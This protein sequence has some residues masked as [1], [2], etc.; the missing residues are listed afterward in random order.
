LP[1]FQYRKR[2]SPRGPS[3][4]ALKIAR[5]EAE[6]RKIEQSPTFGQQFPNVR[7]LEIFWAMKTETGALIADSRTTLKRDKPLLMDLKCEGG[8]G[9]GIFQLTDAI[10][11]GLQN[12]RES[13]AG[14]GTCAAA[15]YKDPLKR[16]GA[17]LD[18][19]V[20]AVYE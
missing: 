13:Y 5:S 17:V 3:K 7:Q 14:V 20:R 6:K 10:K 4:N 19:T 11:N 12:N 8:C 16:C 2:R 9:K 18:Y 1:G 15:S